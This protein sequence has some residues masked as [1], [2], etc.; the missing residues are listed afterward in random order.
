[1]AWTG[2]VFASQLSTSN[3][4]VEK[5]LAPVAMGLPTIFIGIAI[6]EHQERDKRSRIVT[7][8]GTKKQVTVGKIANLLEIPG[9]EARYLLNNLVEEERLRVNKVDENS[10]VYIPAE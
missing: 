2:L 10:V 8:V 3:S 4:N 6:R 9:Q 5:V 1:M 7:E